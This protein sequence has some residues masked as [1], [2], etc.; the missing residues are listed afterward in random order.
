MNT[1]ESIKDF[2]LH[3]IGLIFITLAFL[4]LSIRVLLGYI[5]I[6]PKLFFIL[7]AI[8]G[9]MLIYEMHMKRAVAVMEFIGVL[10]ALF[11]SYKSK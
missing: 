3:H 6:V 11:L 5:I 9:T 10:S 2:S 4:F 8:G 1:I 7:Y